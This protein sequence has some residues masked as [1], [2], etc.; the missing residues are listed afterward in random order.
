MGEP[1]RTNLGMSYLNPSSPLYHPQWVPSTLLAMMGGII[2]T[3]AALLYFVVFFGTF[4]RKKTV[5]EVLDLPESEAYHN[6]ARMS[7]FDSFTP[8]L[9]MMV[10]IILLAYIPTLLDIYQNAGPQAPPY[11][12]TNPIPVLPLK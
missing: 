4:F 1:R 5:L 8:W 11:V 12:P 9:V 2:M 10:V 3:V 7:F 6:E